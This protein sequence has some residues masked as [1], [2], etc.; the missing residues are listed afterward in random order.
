MSLDLL[1][2][3][4][5]AHVPQS[6]TIYATL[7]TS[8]TNASFLHSQLLSRNPSFDYAFIDASS[9]ISRPHLLSAIFN[10]L[11]T[12]LDGTLVSATPHSEVVLALG[13]SNNVFFIFFPLR[14]PPALLFQSMIGWKVTNPRR[15]QKPTADGESH[16]RRGI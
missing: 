9:I 3:L 7:F 13:G 14:P 15:S 5:L 1:E 4:A 16:R 8:V 11:V 12:I 6:H 2:S 10:A